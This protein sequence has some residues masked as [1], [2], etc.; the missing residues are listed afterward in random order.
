V[1]QQ[2]SNQSEMTAKLTKKEQQQMKR[3]VE[4]NINEAKARCEV[5]SKD[6]DKLQTDKDKVEVYIAEYEA[7]MKEET[8]KALKSKYVD[9]VLKDKDRLDKLEERFRVLENERAKMHDQLAHLDAQKLE[10]TKVPAT[11]FSD[12]NEDTLAVLE[13]ELPDDETFVLSSY[14]KKQLSEPF[15]HFMKIINEHWGLVSEAARR[16]IIDLF[17]LESVGDLGQYQVWLEVAKGDEY[18][19][20]KID[21]VVVKSAGSLLSVPK[22]L[23]YLVLVE[24]KEGINETKHWYQI[25]AEMWAC[26]EKRKYIIHGVLTDGKKWVFCR[27]NTD[28]KF[29][30]SKEY[31]KGTDDADIV[32]ILKHLITL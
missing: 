9:A 4:L 1:I 31:I 29:S 6:M 7:M 27:L 2:F 16:T 18:V 21:Y 10:Y 14:E 5:I 11:A 19:T 32:S 8:D 26:S 28:K 12:A 25:I 3:Q 23:A 24:A 30:K 17:L 15:K 20:G 22:H 13:I